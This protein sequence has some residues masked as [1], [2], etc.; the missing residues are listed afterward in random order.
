ML[1]L[2]VIVLEGAVGQTPP[3]PSAVSVAKMQAG[4]AIYARTCQRCHQVHGRGLVGVFPPLAGSDV[5]LEDVPGA[6]RGVLAGRSG[7]PAMPPQPLDDR[8]IAA[9]LTYTLNSWG[10][11][12]GDV[13]ARQVARVRAALATGADR[14]AE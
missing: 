3:P 5:L 2:L 6:I 9:V 1:A 10:N 14:A 7:P 11:E 12:G 13:S 8:E 4:E